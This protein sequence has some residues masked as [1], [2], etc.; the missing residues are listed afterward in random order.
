[1]QGQDEYEQCKFCN[2]IRKKSDIKSALINTKV[3]FWTIKQKHSMCIHCINSQA[4]ENA[5]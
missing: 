2:K 3:M 5:N 1:M 4:N